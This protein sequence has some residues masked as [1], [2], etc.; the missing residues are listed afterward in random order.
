LKID[1]NLIKE[2][3]PMFW[4][5]K[6]VL[7]IS[8]CLLPTAVL[9]V[10]EGEVIVL[11]QGF[12]TSADAAKKD[13]LM[14]AVHSAVGSYLESET[15]IEND[16]LIKE[17]ILQASGSY[18][19]RHEVVRAP[20]KR[21]DG[22]WTT[23]IRAAVRGGQVKERLQSLDIGSTTLDFS[24]IVG[25]KL[26]RITNAKDGAEIFARQFEELLP[27]LLVARLIDKDGKPSKSPQPIVK[28]L[29]DGRLSCTWYV[30]VYFDK[31][32]FYE[33]VVPP[34]DEL[35]SAIASK[36]GGPLVSESRL[37]T[38]HTSRTSYAIFNERTWQGAQPASP[39]GDQPHMY[40]FLSTGCS[41]NGG[42]ERF[43]WYLL[44]G[45][46]YTEVFNARKNPLPA[47]ALNVQFLDEDSGVVWRDTFVPWDSFL[48]DYS[49]REVPTEYVP[50]FKS[51]IE[52]PED[53]YPA[54]TL[55]P[56][57]ADSHNGRARCSAGHCDTVV[58][59]F[60]AVLDPEDL[61]RIK[62]VRFHYAEDKPA[63]KD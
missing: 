11:A 53:A 39:A 45:H 54:T 3:P 63:D 50:Y 59:Q 29:E 41:A 58:K 5:Q 18:V 4:F 44:E 17:E 61:G 1:T 32:L 31:K 14:S 27:K 42:T 46:Q 48:Y 56:R 52:G 43:Q 55:S 51:G 12:G 30:E 13:A 26:G 21:E 23:T 19:Q 8:L 28:V 33:K 6:Y 37:A 15:L 10:E 57:F 62:Q 24:N 40:F 25:E 60:T 47:V 20:E 16:E 34:M 9:A 7:F 49:G 22:L 36:N 35:L 2:K 38:Y